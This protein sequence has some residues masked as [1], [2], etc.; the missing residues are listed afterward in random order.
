MQK[1]LF[2]LALVILAREDIAREHREPAVFG[3][4]RQEEYPSRQDTRATTRTESVKK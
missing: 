1:A 4:P 3:Y 2:V